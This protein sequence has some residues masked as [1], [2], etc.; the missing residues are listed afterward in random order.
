MRKTNKMG[1]AAIELILI[2]PLVLVF[3]WGFMSLFKIATERRVALMAAEHLQKE[4]RL[5][6]ELAL[7]VLDRPCAVHP[8][9]CAGRKQ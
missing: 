6:E 8:L 9:I 5:R 3:C 2:L 1:M 7:P 4:R